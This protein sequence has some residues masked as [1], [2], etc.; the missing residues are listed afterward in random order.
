MKKNDETPNRSLADFRAPVE[1]QIPDYLG[2][3]AVT[4]GKEV[5]IIADDYRSN[6]DDYKC[7]LIQGLR[8]RLAEAYP[9]KIHDES[10]KIL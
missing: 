1:N 7:I 6:N 3:F 9:E 4:A 2:A 10:I 8:Q 5:N